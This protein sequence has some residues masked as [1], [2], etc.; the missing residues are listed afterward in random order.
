MA[1]FMVD[2][3]WAVL[4]ACARLPDSHRKKGR[5][6]WQKSIWIHSALRP[7]A[8]RDNATDKKSDEKQ[9]NE[10]TEKKVR[11]KRSEAGADERS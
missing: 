4:V 7:A 11:K 10:V 3:T 9:S 2:K 1:A 8:L 5:L 6:A